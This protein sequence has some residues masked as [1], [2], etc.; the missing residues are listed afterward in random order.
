MDRESTNVQA[1]GAI[2]LVVYWD[3][4]GRLDVVQGLHKDV[5]DQRKKGFL[6][7]N[8]DGLFVILF[9]AAFR[10]SGSHVLRAENLGFKR[11]VETGMN[12]EVDRSLHAD[13]SASF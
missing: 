7:G 8:G 9:L 11:S 6:V 12:Q 10:S 3:G 13:C 1:L 4:R 5:L 2:Q